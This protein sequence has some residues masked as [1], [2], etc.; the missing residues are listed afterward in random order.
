MEAKVL[1]WEKTLK[2]QLSTKI[3]LKCGRKDQPR[4]TPTFGKMFNSW[5]RPNLFVKAWQTQKQSMKIVE[6]GWKSERTKL[7]KVIPVILFFL[8]N[9]ITS[10]TVQLKKWDCVA[11][12]YRWRRI[13]QQHWYWYLWES[14]KKLVNRSWKKRHRE[15]KHRTAT[16]YE[17]SVLSFRWC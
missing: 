1:D 4:S 9:L 11:Q 13:L 16:L 10:R 12:K 8:V 3:Y 15:L 17:N 6:N 5:E 2:H 7:L 14:N